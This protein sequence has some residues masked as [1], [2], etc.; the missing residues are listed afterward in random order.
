MSY[1]IYP[2]EK[3]ISVKRHLSE[4]ANNINCDNYEKT[5]SFSKHEEDKGSRPV[6]H[7][8]A[9]QEEESELYAV[10]KMRRENGKKEAEA[11]RRGKALENAE[12]PGKAAAAPVQPLHA[13]TGKSGSERD[14]KE[15]RMR[16][17]NRD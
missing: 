15:R 3:H 17:K 12:T 6:R 8:N 1:H 16:L 5:T 11:G 4:T 7:G 10:R 9:L 13:R 2:C 14:V